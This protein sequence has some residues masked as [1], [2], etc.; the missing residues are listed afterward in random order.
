MT[1]VIF[2]HVFSHKR[3]RNTKEELATLIFILFE[4]LS[5]LVIEV[6][7]S[8]IPTFTFAELDDSTNGNRQ[9]SLL[10]DITAVNY[11]GTCRLCILVSQSTEDGM[12]FLKT[13]DLVEGSFDSTTFENDSLYV[14]PVDEE[15]NEI[16][17]LIK[18]VKDSFGILL[19]TTETIYYLD[20]E[21]L[22]RQID[23]EDFKP[24]NVIKS[25]DFNFIVDDV[26]E[27]IPDH[28]YLIIPS[29]FDQ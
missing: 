21:P 12:Q 18:P 8:T 9:A 29:D 22:Y 4:S 24:Q 19:V 20:T 23:Q 13:F 14:V 27:L 15:T 17:Y 16:S 7:A 1:K 11:D 5:Y 6:T 25:Y 10:Q 26:I 3:V 2:S 28:F